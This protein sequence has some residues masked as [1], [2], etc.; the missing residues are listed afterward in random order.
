MIGIPLTEPAFVFGDNQ[1]VLA[2][3]T[4]LASMLKKKSHSLAFHHVREGCAR[5]ECRTAYVNTRNN[6]DDLFTKPIPSGEKR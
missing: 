5:D 3:A 4:N 1:S 6:V 2:N